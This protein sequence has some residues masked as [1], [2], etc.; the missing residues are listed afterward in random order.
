MTRGTRQM[1]VLL[2]I[3]GNSTYYSLR[4]YVQYQHV[5]L[6]GTLC[7]P[8]CDNP[9]NGDASGST[10]LFFLKFAVARNNANS[11]FDAD[12]S[13]VLSDHSKHSVE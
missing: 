4:K 10:V 9:T 12:F 2:T 7:A 5:N 1:Y 11:S 3:A 13:K 8:L 6:C